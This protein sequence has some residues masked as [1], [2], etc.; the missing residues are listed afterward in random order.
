MPTTPQAVPG[1]VVKTMAQQAQPHMLEHEATR[2]MVEF[3][4]GR[5]DWP[6][7]IKGMFVP[8]VLGP[9]VHDH[10]TTN[11]NYLKR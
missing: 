9:N 10:G 3:N 7:F 5:G 11:S 2:T 6:V 8:Y 1:W 4:E